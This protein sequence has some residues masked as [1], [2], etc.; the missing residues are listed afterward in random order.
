M[1]M[2]VR[3]LTEVGDE[4]QTQIYYEIVVGST[5]KIIRKYS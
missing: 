1:T 2:L 4:I 5:L 3:K